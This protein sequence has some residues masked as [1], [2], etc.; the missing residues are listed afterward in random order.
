MTA[1][2]FHP[3]LLMPSILAVSIGFAFNGANAAEHTLMP[4]P[5]TVHIG[6]F[7]AA[8]KPV[9]TINSGDTVTIETATSLDPVEIDQSG[10]VPASVVPEYQR[11]IH[12]EVKDRGPSGHVLTGPIFVNGAQPGDTLEV[13]IQEIELAVDYGYNRQRPYTGTL[14]DEFPGFFQRIIPIDRN[15]KTAVVAPG[16]VVPV[17]R[18]FFGVMGVAPLPSMGRI[19]TSP[20]GVHTGNI[21]NRDMVAGTTLF[22]PVYAAGALFSVGDAHAAQ[23][24]GEVDL[25]AIETG[26]RGKFQFIVRKDMKLTWPRA[27]TPTHWMVMGLNPNL[28]EAMKIA[29]RETILF[30]TQ[31]FPKLSREEAYMIASVAVDYHVTQV[32]DGTKGIHGMIPKAIFAAQ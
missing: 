13:R 23:G 18:P 30:I 3:W 6:H 2:K 10:A 9:L 27:E 22:M 16:V 26:N 1:R 14:P 25:S 17:N 31:R 19:S 28:E 20:P 15:A 24:Q 4:S 11:A 8:L 32:V 21:D 12:R 5:Q 29:V 7:S